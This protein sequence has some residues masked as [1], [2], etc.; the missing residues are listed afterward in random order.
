MKLIFATG[1][2]DKFGRAFL[3]AKKNGITLEQEDID[4][5]EIQ[6]EFHEEILK[7]KLK[8]AYELLQQPVIV[9]DDAWSIPELNG[10][11]GSYMKSMSEWLSAEDFLRLCEPLKKRETILHQYLAYTDGEHEIIL[12]HDTEGKILKEARGPE[13]G[14]SWTRIVVLNEGHGDMTIAEVR[15]A[16]DNKDK[17]L[18]ENLDSAAS[19]VWNQMF[20]QIK[21]LG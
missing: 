17:N 19:T 3:V 7:D 2:K 8:K 11:P 21:E 5:D 9:S 10:F 12:N 6:S 4:I 15:E 18:K 1:N 13:D 20:K 14:A 16:R